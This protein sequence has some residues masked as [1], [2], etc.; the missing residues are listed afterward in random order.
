MTV[1]AV[2]WAVVDTLHAALGLRLPEL[3]FARLG[4]NVAAFGL[5]IEIHYRHYQFY[6][7]MVVASGVAYVCYRVKLASLTNVGLYDLVFICLEIVF[8]ATSRDT[9]RKYYA[10]SQQLLATTMTELPKPRD[11]ERWVVTSPPTPHAPEECSR[12]GPQT[13]AASSASFD[14][15]PAAEI[16]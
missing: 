2:R 4:D 15:L 7:N 5:L 10:R 14:S 16:N 11:Q 3:N 1:S 12:P 6:S 9:L 13:P 8:F